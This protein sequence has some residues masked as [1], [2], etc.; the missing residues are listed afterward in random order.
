MT[1]PPGPATTDDRQTERVQP[2]VVAWHIVGA[3][4]PP[5]MQA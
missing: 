4:C 1:P 5:T 3:I 2:P